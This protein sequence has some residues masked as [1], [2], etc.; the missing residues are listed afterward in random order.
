MMTKSDLFNDTG[1]WTTIGNFY[2]SNHCLIYTI[3][4]KKLSNLSSSND[5]EPTL[6]LSDFFPVINYSH[7]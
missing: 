6:S 2:I 4:L 5:E 7:Y 1:Q 3:F